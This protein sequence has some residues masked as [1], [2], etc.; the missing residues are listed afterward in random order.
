MELL[1]HASKICLLSGFEKGAVECLNHAIRCCCN[2]QDLQMAR[3][4]YDLQASLYFQIKQYECAGKA[5]L[6]LRDLYADLTDYTALA[7]T[8]ER[9]GK[10]YVMSNQRRIALSY[11]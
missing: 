7:E 8:Y 1:R 11:F 3:R 4:L 2:C 9:M 6:R 5:L 10:C